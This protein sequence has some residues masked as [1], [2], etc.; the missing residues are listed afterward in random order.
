[1]PLLK[2]RLAQFTLAELEAL[3]ES[4]LESTSASAVRNNLQLRTQGARRAAG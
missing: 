3:A 2:D 1:V 4:C